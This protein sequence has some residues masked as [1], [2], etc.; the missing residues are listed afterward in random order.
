MRWLRRHGRPVSAILV[1]L[2]VVAGIVYW[3][4]GRDGE[5]ACAA[6]GMEVVDGECIGVTDGAFTE[7]DDAS[8]GVVEQI[9][10]QNAEV[11]DE[12]VNIAL[13][14]PLSQP[15]QSD[16]PGDRPRQGQLSSD[17]VRQMLI[18]AA[19]A[20][21][22]VNAGRVIGD[23]QPKVR[24]LLANQGGYQT[25]WRRPVEELIARAGAEDPHRRVV[26]VAALGTSVADTRDAAM[27]LSAARVPIIGAITTAD[28][29][30]YASIPGMLRVTPTTSEFVDALGTY[31]EPRP[32]YGP[33]I[34][35]WDQNAE[36]RGDLYAGALQRA[37]HARLHRWIGDLP[38]QAYVGASIPSESWPQMFDNV[39]INVCQSGAN[40]ILYA[41]R[42]TDLPAFIDS[43]ELR[44]CRDRPLTIMT[45]VTALTAIDRGSA[46]ELRS[47][48]LTV[49]YA[50]V[51]DPHRWPHG[52]GNPPG[53]WSDY[54]DA[55]LAHGYRVTDSDAYT[56]LSHDAILTATRAMR[57]AAA[58]NRLPK[59]VDV[60]GQLRNINGAYTVPG[61]SGSFSFTTMSNGAPL[62]TPIQIVTIPQ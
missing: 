24:L 39:T 59:S 19:I 2:V 11:G 40:T 50:G 13:L 10:K 44:I 21:K 26:A 36:G 27:A 12:Y 8:T 42:I 48:G 58:P 16:K 28:E 6:A 17:Q 15:R 47:A 1:V 45:G 41:G 46:E 55:L 54:S 4:V 3:V 57:L 30:S 52:D 31:L 14:G 53:G 18:G 5:N 62:G 20:Q 37:F 25:R 60:G 43:L 38:D 34:V 49:V 51:T 22:R 9:R 56:C 61:C 23:P 33:A 29:L 32:Q 7:F 35:V